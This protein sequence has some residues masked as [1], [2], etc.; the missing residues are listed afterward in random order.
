MLIALKSMPNGS[1][2]LP[3]DKWEKTAR[4]SQ[5][6]QVISMF[7]VRPCERPSEKEREM[8]NSRFYPKQLLI[9]TIFWLHRPTN[10]ELPMPSAIWP[11]KIKLIRFTMEFHV[12]TI[13]FALPPPP[14]GSII[15]L[16]ILIASPLDSSSAR[17]PANHKMTWIGNS[18]RT[19]RGRPHSAWRPWHWKSSRGSSGIRGKAP[20]PPWST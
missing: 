2:L 16:Q 9:S 10:N 14:I 12:I 20:M 4:K 6:N 3:H 19:W 8:V 5:V 18:R 17:W 15:R 7:Y 13:L 11:M 1:D